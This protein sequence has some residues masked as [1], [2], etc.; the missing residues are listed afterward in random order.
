MSAKEA[1]WHPLTGGAAVWIFMAVEV[2]TF[3]LFLLGHAWGWRSEPEVFAQAQALLHPGS[4]VRGT[5]L[6]VGGSWLA[7]Q[8]VL[9]RE[10]EP[11]MDV[12]RALAGAA[13]LGVLFT[14]NKI[15]E[16]ASLGGVNLSTN[17]FWFSYLFLTFLHLL[18]VIAGIGFF[19]WLAWKCRGG[20]PAPD[21]PISVEAAAAYWHL[22][23]LIWVLLFPLLYLLHP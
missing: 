9:R 5:A 21:D 22:V 15:A 6:L 20:A 19:A 14:L 23:D 2:V 1:R 4:A 7:Y 11:A 8:A 18:H 17:A 3:G 12:S 10:G 13:G 16:Y